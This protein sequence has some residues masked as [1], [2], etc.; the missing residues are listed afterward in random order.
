MF[1]GAAALVEA[2]AASTRGGGTAG[3]G[4]SRIDIPAGSL[5]LRARAAD[6]VGQMVAIG[7]SSIV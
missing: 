1:A 7:F 4:T 5:Y 6:M 2:D 3:T